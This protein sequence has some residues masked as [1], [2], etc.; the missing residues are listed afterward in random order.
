LI[1]EFA[2]A[3]VTT[4]KAPAIVRRETSFTGLTCSFAKFAL[5]L[6]DGNIYESMTLGTI[7]VDSRQVAQG[8][9][10]RTTPIPVYDYNYF[11]EHTVLKGDKPRPSGEVAVVVDFDHQGQ[12]LGGPA[13]LT[14]KVNGS[15]VADGKMKATVGGRFGIDTSGIGEDSGQPVA[16]DYKAP[17]KFNGEIEKVVVE[18]NK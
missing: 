13:T 14:L 8:R 17:V 1:D 11:E 2:P 5:N 4:G 16:F 12:N 3:V 9:V 6:N 15:K 10:K 18:S 7:T